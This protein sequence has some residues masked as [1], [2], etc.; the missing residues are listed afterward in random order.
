LNSKD[1][2]VWKTLSSSLKLKSKTRREDTKIFYFP[3]TAKIEIS[4]FWRKKIS[5]FCWQMGLKISRGKMFIFFFAFFKRRERFR[6]SLADSK[7]LIPVSFWT[8]LTLRSPN[9][10]F[11][12]FASNLTEPELS[13]RGINQPRQCLTWLEAGKHLNPWI[14]WVKCV[15]W[16]IF[17]QIKFN[18]SPWDFQKS[19]EAWHE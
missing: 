5:F 15:K 18:I 10:K 13:K 6:E 11:Y 14:I 9:L 12:A 16:M 7:I 8:F 17:N 2:L 4:V 3:N 1:L 19:D